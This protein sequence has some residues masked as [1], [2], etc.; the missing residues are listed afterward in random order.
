VMNISEV[1]LPL[2]FS[3]N[4]IITVVEF[5]V[6]SYLV[7]VCARACVRVGARVAMSACSEGPCKV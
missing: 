3:I 6:N 1:Q 2:S 4:K 5:S 7:C